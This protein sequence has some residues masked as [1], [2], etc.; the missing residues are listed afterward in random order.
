LKKLPPIAQE[1]VEEYLNAT[2]EIEKQLKLKEEQRKLEEAILGIVQDNSKFLVKANVD[3][4]KINANYDLRLA[5]IGKTEEEQKLLNQQAM[6]QEKLAEST[7]KFEEQRL[8]IAVKFAKLKADPTSNLDELNAV[9]EAENAK[10]REAKA[11]ADQD[12]NRNVAVTAAEDYYKE[13]QKIGKP[14]S[15]A[16]TTALFE[17]GQAGAKSLRD[18]VVAAFRNKI[19]VWI[20]A[21]IME[22]LTGNGGSGNIFW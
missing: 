17:G 16:I 20:E 18:S 3:S 6:I 10:L 13:M 2:S 9:Q 1:L 11:K 7:A 8:A 19:S 5:L 4:E 21:N 15:Q 22:M 14:V 12:I